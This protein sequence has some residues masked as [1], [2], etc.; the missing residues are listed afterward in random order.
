M[1]PH[2][3]TNPFELAQILD[4]E[5]SV[6][7]QLIRFCPRNDIAFLD[8]FGSFSREE[9]TRDSD[10]DLLVSFSE[11]KSLIEHIRMK[12]ELEDLLG[13]KVDMVTENSLSPYI[14]PHV[15][16]IC[17]NCIVKDNSIFSAFCEEYPQSSP[18]S[19]ASSSP[20]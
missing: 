20:R 12:N 18:P 9:Q 10:I 17:K 11:T 1:N 3:I 2:R 5:R 8:L 13:T 4:L 14:A 19:S 6:G 15:Q 16:E 7:E